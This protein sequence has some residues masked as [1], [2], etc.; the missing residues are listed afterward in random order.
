MNLG[1][2]QNGKQRSR[3][4][5][6]NR[7]TRRRAA[8]G[9]IL[10]LTLAVITFL[11]QPITPP[12][13]QSALSRAR[14]VLDSTGSSPHIDGARLRLSRGLAPTAEQIVS[15]KVIQF[16]KSRREITRAIAAHFGE[17]IPA[18]VEKFYDAIEAGDWKETDRLFNLMA[19]RS[20]QYD[21]SEKADPRLN[22]FWPAVLETYGAAEQAHDWPAEELLKYGDDVLGNLRPGSV[23]IGG[24]DPGRFIPTLLN[25]TSAGEHHPVLTQNALADSRYLEYIQFLYGDRLHLPNDQDSHKIFADYIADAQ[26]RFEH[27]EQFPDEPRQ[28]RHREELKMVEGKLAAGGSTAVM[29]I[30]ERLLNF[31][32]EKNPET[33]FALQESFPFKTTYREATPLGPIMELRARPDSTPLPETDA[34]QSVDYWRNVANATA[35]DHSSEEAL[36]AYSHMAVAQGNL[37]AHEGHAAQA[38]ET[39][40]LSL[41]IYP[42]NI[43]TL[44]NYSQFLQQSGRADEARSLVDR[45]SQNHPDLQ[46]ELTKWLPPDAKPFLTATP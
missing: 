31:I 1:K 23:Y 24:S 4:L 8:E 28:V 17:A 36:K 3:F 40:R 30:N 46:K 45:F 9:V 41:D 32:L 19:K 6:S 14:E 26:K 37:L 44:L 15:G 21:G 18:E 13:F 11:Y 42:R 10:L 16:G 2:N 29:D 22:H 5:P 7:C 25:E 34:A 27:D 35:T 33:A 38:E 12:E 43:D 20:G 39:Y